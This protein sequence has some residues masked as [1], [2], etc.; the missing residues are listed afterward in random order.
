MFSENGLGLPPASN[1]QISDDHH[2]LVAGGPRKAAVTLGR[3][4][5]PRR[6]AG[7][8][9]PAGNAARKRPKPAA[10]SPAAAA[11]AGGR[12]GD[13]GGAVPQPGAVTELTTRSIATAAAR[14]QRHARAVTS[15]S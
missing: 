11:P 4:G 14:A 13:A 15:P 5:S 1:C 7:P 6:L 3:T 10:S 8:A 2:S 9:S 12:G